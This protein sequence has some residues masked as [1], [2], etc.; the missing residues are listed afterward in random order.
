MVDGSTGMNSPDSTGVLF[1]FALCTTTTSSASIAAFELHLHPL[2][3]EIQFVS[4]SACQDNGSAC[5]RANEHEDTQAMQQKRAN[6]NVCS[7]AAHYFQILGSMQ[8]APPPRRPHVWNDT[9]EGDWS[10]DASSE[11]DSDAN[12]EDGLGPDSMAQTPESNPGAS[13]GGSSTD[14]LQAVA[15]PLAMGCPSARAA[16][17]PTS[18]S[19]P[20]KQMGSSVKRDRMAQQSLRRGKRR[21]HYQSTLSA[22]DVYADTTES[23]TSAGGYSTFDD[24]C[25]PSSESELEVDHL[26]VESDCPGEGLAAGED[27]GGG[28]GSGALPDHQPPSMAHDRLSPIPASSVSAPSSPGI[29][30]PPMRRIL[31]RFMLEHRRWLEA[32]AAGSPG[33][34]PEVQIDAH[35]QIAAPSEHDSELE[36]SDDGKF[37]TGSSACHVRSDNEYDDSRGDD[38]TDS[39]D[40]G[41]GSGESGSESGSSSPAG[42][43]YGFDFDPRD[44]EW[45]R[46]PPWYLKPPAPE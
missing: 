43:Y 16:P 44:G 18:A 25:D 35:A 26:D 1:S 41:G 39:D 29:I 12:C 20:V 8:N 42:F 9:Q 15:H 28:S 21:A 27:G 23:D 6:V 13:K 5:D 7:V 32:P 11:H 36:D 40:S 17:I 38:C 4:M 19:H 46:R 37:S 30:S 14:V 34:Q 45:Y 10:E 31:P 22:G 24:G 2:C 33:A 3:T